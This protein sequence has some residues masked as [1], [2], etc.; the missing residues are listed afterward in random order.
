M[1]KSSGVWPKAESFLTLF[2]FFFFFFYIT[3]KG[4]TDTFSALNHSICQSIDT[5]MHKK[6]LI[7]NYRPWACSGATC[8]RPRV[9]D[10]YVEETLRP[11][12][13]IFPPARVTLIQ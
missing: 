10:W 4:I 11:E 2:F 7:K 3:T 1:R 8:P 6:V 9:D 5:N 13:F 12:S